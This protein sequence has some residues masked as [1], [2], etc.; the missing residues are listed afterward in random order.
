LW[1]LLASSVV[2]VGW[3]FTL[4]RPRRRLAGLIPFLTLAMLVAWPYTEAGR[5][6]V[7]LLPCLLIGAAEG[8]TW[9]GRHGARLLGLGVSRRSI[10]TTAAVLILAASIPYPLYLALTRS[11][12]ASAA[13]NREFDAACGWLKDEARRPGTV[14]TRHPG[15]V[16]LA[17][18][19]PAL[20]VSTSERAAEPEAGTV[21]I[22]RLITR[23]N[24][25]YLL[26][27]EDRYLQ[28]APS[29]LPRF[30]AAAPTRVRK[31]WSRQGERSR[32]TIYEVI[33]AYVDE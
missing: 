8:V 1:A 29:P 20:E 5:F 16:F 27:D 26:I 28:A 22:E 33:P 17:T 10:R 21:A 7:P 15:E 13:E 3:L 6:L 32:V 25:A 2:I 4:K 18:G 30:V 11:S 14:L 31:V 19:R 23:Y 12:R 24:V 9:F